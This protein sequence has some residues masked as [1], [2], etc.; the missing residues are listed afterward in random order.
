M[1]DNL[2]IH[3]DV[4]NRK[5]PIRIKRTDTNSEEI[6]REAARKLT[7]TANQISKKNVKSHDEIDYL[8]MAGLR[9]AISNE[10]HERK[11]ELEPLL[12]ELRG[13]NYQLSSYLED[14]E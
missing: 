12:E 10:E 14:E 9:F 11:S 2:L 3:V 13:L 5:Y 1:D 4:L 7:Y 6:I 8:A